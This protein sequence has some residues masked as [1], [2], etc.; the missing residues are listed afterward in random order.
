V[1]ERTGEEGHAGHERPADAE[2][3]K[4]HGELLR[5]AGKR[6]PILSARTSHPILAAAA[7]E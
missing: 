6:G 7:F 5:T 4:T 3:V 1:A 2:D